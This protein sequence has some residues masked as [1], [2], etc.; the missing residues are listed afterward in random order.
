MPWAFFCQSHWCITHC[1]TKNEQYLLILKF[2]F[3]SK[4]WCLKLLKLFE[5]GCPVRQYVFGVIT[6]LEFIQRCFLEHFSSLMWV[7]F[8]NHKIKINIWE[9]KSWT[10]QTKSD[11]NL[12]M[13]AKTGFSATYTNT[14]GS[15]VVWLNIIE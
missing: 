11:Q 1:F 10:L 8:Q 5:T 9:K 4:G 13:A 6:H 14:S 12:L 15:P 7:I 2:P 3:T